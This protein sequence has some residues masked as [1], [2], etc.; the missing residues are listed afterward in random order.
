MNNRNRVRYSLV[1]AA[2]LL[3]SGL[4]V[5]SAFRVRFPTQGGETDEFNVIKYSLTHD[6]KRGQGGVFT[7]TSLDK[8]TGE[9]EPAKTEP[10]PCPT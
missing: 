8:P 5:F 10:E 2:V 3:F 7:V 1:F 4:L 9:G 6:I